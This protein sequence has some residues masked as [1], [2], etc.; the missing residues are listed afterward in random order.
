MIILAKLYSCV[1]FCVSYFYNSEMLTAAVMADW[2]LLRN[3]HNHF[4]FW[5]SIV[6]WQPIQQ[7]WAS[8]R[9]KVYTVICSPYT[10]YQLLIIKFIYCTSPHASK[11]KRMHACMRVHVC[12]CACMYIYVPCVSKHAY[13]HIYNCTSTYHMYRYTQHMYMDTYMYTH[14]H[15]IK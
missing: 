11:H 5:W 7:G 9:N 8:A 4:P 2:R 1:T 10:V 15:T 6:W 3:K 13:P 14:T 12:A